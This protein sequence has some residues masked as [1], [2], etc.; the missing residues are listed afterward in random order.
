M[1]KSRKFP[2]GLAAVG[3]A[4]AVALV[5]STVAGAADVTIEEIIVTATKRAEKLQDV[6]IA[7]SAIGAEDIRARGFT[8]FADFLNSVPGVYF[9]DGGPG[10]SVVHIRGA[11]EAGGGAIVA[12]Y[13]GETLTSV[14]T[15]HGGKPN[16]RLVDIDRVEVLRGPQGT[17]FGTD[18]LAGVIRTIPAAP[19]LQ[20]FTV[21]L[22]TRGFATKHSDDMSYHLE[23]AVNIPLIDN[24]LALRV[25]A[26]QDDIAGYI[27]NVVPDQPAVDYGGPLGEALLGSPLP[28]GLLVTPAIGAFTRRDINSEDT[29]GARAALTWQATDRLKFDLT[30]AH[31]D[32]KLDSEPYA[33][34]AVGKYEQRR[35]L[36]VYQQG[37]YGEKLD[38]GSFVIAY[39]WD[40]VSLTS[41]TSYMEMDRFTNQDITFLAEGSFGA[42][43]PWSLNDTSLG[44]LF[45]QEVRLQSRGEDALQWTVGA[46]Y[47][48]EKS[49]LSQFVPD[50]S[51]PTCLPQLLFGEDFAFTAPNQKFY[52][53]EQRAVFGEVSYSFTPRWTV[54]VGARYLEDDIESGS[55]SAE[56]LLAGGTLEGSSN[57]GSADETNPSGYLRFKATDD[58]TLYL[59][60]GRG[61]RSGTVNQVLPDA[62]SAQAAAVGL[63]SITDPDTMWNYELGFKSQLADGRVALNAAVY[64]EEW[65][66]VQLGIGLECGFS[67]SVNGGDAEG[68]GVEIEA[69]IQAT[70]A[71]SFNFSYS[72][73][74]MEFTKV[75]PGTGF[76][77]GQR[78]PDA[79][80]EN[81]SAGVQYSFAMGETWAG[82]ARADYTYVGDVEASVAGGTIVLDPYDVVNLR[83]GFSHDTFAL[84]F[85]GRNVTDERGVLVNAGPAQGNHENLIRPLEY[86]VELR[87][88]FR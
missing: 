58:M 74:Q 66:D 8:Q 87:Y 11:S 76:V 15:N 62:C 71:W 21:D 9:Q 32:V 7:I 46:F 73:N 2:R 82:F 69:T 4:G 29:W 49:D 77:E 63:K 55:P 13:F 61:F 16:L 64:Q 19:D 75:Q 35:S 5:I 83:L 40:A 31:Q 56:G 20:N 70:D 34:P 54:G 52:D 59:Q 22:G 67:G 80:Q 50:F 33:D 79:P 10:T 78:L 30:Y 14:L 1:N 68:K 17:V 36:D 81:G 44:K 26:Y 28:D 88:S 45:T 38:I 24:K 48:E 41:A 72:H 3:S 27:D 60:A 57:S 42:P 47:M 65:K 18:A 12:T 43:I 37:G 39:D 84:E 6:P 86:G 53:K 25:V 51:C 85:F 23:G